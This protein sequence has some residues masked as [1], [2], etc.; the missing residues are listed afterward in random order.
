[1]ASPDGVL[2]ARFNCLSEFSLVLVDAAG[3][4]D[5]TSDGVV[6]LCENHAAENE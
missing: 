2:Q 3:I 1:M 6:I 5:K 4:V